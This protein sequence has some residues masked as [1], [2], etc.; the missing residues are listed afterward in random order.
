[1]VGGVTGHLAGGMS[2]SDAKELGDAIDPGQAG[3]VIVGESKVE[4]AMKKAVTRA[5]KQTAQELGVDP[6]DIDK[7]LQQAVKEM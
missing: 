3:L 1:M 4:D 2:R 5:E 7:A 6:K